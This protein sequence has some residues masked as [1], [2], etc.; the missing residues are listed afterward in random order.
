MVRLVAHRQNPQAI[1]DAPRWR[2][3]MEEPAI[4][5][6]PGIAQETV[7]D[8]ARRGHQIVKTEKFAP[9]STPYGSAMMFGGAQMIYR[10]DDGYLGASDG[11]RDGQAVG[12]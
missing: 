7:D 9:A 12:F 2:I 4:L 8:L 3:A 1:L 5:L 11:R 6:E 10:L